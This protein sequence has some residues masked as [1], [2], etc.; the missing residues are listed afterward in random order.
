MAV[1]EKFPPCDKAIGP[2]HTG[3]H[4]LV[5][6]A[7]TS[8]R[9]RLLEVGDAARNHF[10]LGPCNPPEVQ[11]QNWRMYIRT[12]K[13]EACTGNAPVHPGESPDSV[14]R[15]IS[16]SAKDTWIKKLQCMKVYYKGGGV[17]SKG[18]TLRA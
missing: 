11:E 16:M 15:L 4:R 14:L 5:Q 7:F 6:E 2:S 1:C 10:G 18:T 9:Q 17:G 3:A 12:Y 13:V 8:I